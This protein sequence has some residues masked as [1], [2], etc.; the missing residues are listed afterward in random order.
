[1]ELNDPNLFIEINK[2]EI[3][4]FAVDN[5]NDDEFKSIFKEAP[6]KEYNKKITDLEL[7][8]NIIKKNIYSI[9]QKINFVFKET[10]L[11]INNF[12]CTF[13]N[14]SGYKN[15][16]LNFKEN[17]TYILNSLKA[18]SMKL[19]AIRLFYIFSTQIIF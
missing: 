1:M 5:I 3:L 18:K 10:I 14:F 12:E 19:K 8:Y 6:Y 16:E 9:E 2:N 7:I 11:V 13:T 17:I 4:F 15:N